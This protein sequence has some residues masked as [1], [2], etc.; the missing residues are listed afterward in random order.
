MNFETFYEEFSE[1]TH[2]LGATESPLSNGAAF[3]TFGES[4]K[5]GILS[6]VHGDEK[7]GPLT[8]LKWVQELK[9]IKTSFWVCP[10]LNDQG[11]DKD[12][13]RWNALDLNRNFSKRS[14]VPLL[15]ECY[16]FFK[17]NTPKI[18]LDLH[19]DSFTRKN[20]IYHY[21]TE[22]TTF[23]EYL[24]KGKNA[25]IIWSKPSE[26]KGC[27]ENLMQSLG[28]QY[29]ATIEAS[30]YFKLDNRSKWLDTVLKRT[31]KF[32]ERLD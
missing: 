5:I 13:R 25:G 23:A 10:L 17:K 27:S 16:R 7:S 9:K 22:D 1:S 24:S 28:T 14:R 6:G 31:F 19:E 26:W 21:I 2:R 11:W 18:F 32:S 12:T 8:L 30:P 20:Y 3:Y 4:P 29:M 15:R